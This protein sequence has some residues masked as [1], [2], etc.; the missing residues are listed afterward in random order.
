MGLLEPTEGML[1]VD[2]E[3]ITSVN[4]RA[5]QAHIAHVPQAIFLADSSVEENIALGIP[6]DQINH[7]RVREAARQAQIANTIENW[8]NQY[9][10]FVGERGI[11]LSGGQ[12]QRMELLERF[13]NNRMLLFSTKLLA[14]SIMKQR[15]L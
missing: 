7:S 1:T 12:R 14:R 8:P 2:G 4:R 11:R 13:I 10:T 6:K 5:W 3:A 15:V 9:K